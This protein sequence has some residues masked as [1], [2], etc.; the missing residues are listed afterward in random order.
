MSGIFLS[1]QLLVRVKGG[2]EKRACLE[3]ILEEN[4]E[5]EE[6]PESLLSIT[7]CFD[8][9]KCPETVF[10]TMQRILSSWLLK[11]G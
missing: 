1:E 11:K 9:G 4:E 10:I 7:D 2:L 5:D 3:E 6:D 8:L